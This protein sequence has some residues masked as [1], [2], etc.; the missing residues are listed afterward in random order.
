MLIHNSHHLQVPP[1]SDFFILTPSL[2]T[3][4]AEQLRQSNTRCPCK[5]PSG[6]GRS[7]HLSVTPSISEDKMID[8]DTPK[9]ILDNL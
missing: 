1:V 5:R 8:R 4:G 6:V 2:P 7:C 9:L 3:D